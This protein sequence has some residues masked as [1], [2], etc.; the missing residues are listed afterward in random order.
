MQKIGQKGFTLVEG[1][2]VVIALCLVGGVGYYVYNS[3]QNK[4]SDKS[5]TSASETTQSKTTPSEKKYLEISE[6]GI[7]V[8]LSNELADM[9][10]SIPQEGEIMLTSKT[11][12]DLQ[13]KACGVDE[14][15]GVA[16]A[17]YDRIM[18]ISKAEG[19]HTAPAHGTEDFFLKQFDGFYINGSYGNLGCGDATESAAM[20]AYTDKSQKLYEVTN[21]AVK[22]SELL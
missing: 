4:N 20:K 14:Q 11:L 5:S 6:L 18:S 21:E 19:Q 8:P 15:S 7:K 3:S 13:I 17:G 22:N 1:L 9:K 12:G 10:Y 2:L 16:S